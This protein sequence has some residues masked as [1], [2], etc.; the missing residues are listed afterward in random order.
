VVRHTSKAPRPPKTEQTGGITDDENGTLDGSCGFFRRRLLLSS[1]VPVHP[2]NPISTT[3]H[4]VFSASRTYVVLRTYDSRFALPRGRSHVSAP[5][6]RPFIDSGYLQLLITT[7]SGGHLRSSPS[8]PEVVRP[9]VVASHD[10]L[11]VVG[12]Y[13]LVGHNSRQLLLFP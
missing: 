4:T 9:L 7:R 3:W 1:H 6:R 12:S 10:P 8:P 13:V 2:L 5:R 11:Q